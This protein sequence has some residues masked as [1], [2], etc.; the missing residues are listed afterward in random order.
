VTDPRDAQRKAD[1]GT[2]Q[3]AIEAYAKA[4]GSY[5][6]KGGGSRGTGMGW[7]NLPYP[8]AISVAKALH[9]GGYLAASSVDDPDPAK[10][11]GYMIYLC[12][13]AK[14]YSIS[15]TLEHPTAADV[16]HAQT[17]CNGTGPNGTYAVYGKNYSVGN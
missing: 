11:P 5:Q 16:A 3:A 7:I 6:A 2:L 10:R 1:L 14:Q 13:E 17:T 8:G 9:D 4:N 12:N 15:A